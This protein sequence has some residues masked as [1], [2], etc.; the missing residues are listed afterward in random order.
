MPVGLIQLS[1]VLKQDSF[2]SMISLT[3]TS[4]VGGHASEG[5]ATLSPDADFCNN[6]SSACSAWKKEFSSRMMSTR[7]PPSCEGGGQLV[8]RRSSSSM[9][10]YGSLWC[11]F[12]FCQCCTSRRSTKPSTRYVCQHA[13]HGTRCYHRK[14]DI[15]S[16][17]PKNNTQT[18]SSLSVEWHQLSI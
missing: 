8:C 2:F 16:W 12:L 3:A 1:A 15:R 7:E 10:T 6:I 11:D 17:A 13:E 5:S 14:S 4:S 18:F 9:R